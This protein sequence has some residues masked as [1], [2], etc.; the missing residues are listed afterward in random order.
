MRVKMTYNA[1]PTSSCGS[2]TYG[3]VE[4]YTVNISLTARMEDASNTAISFNLYPNP[5]NGEVLNISNL[6]VDSNYR[7]FNMIGQ[8]FG[9]GKI[10][11]QSINVGSLSSGTYLIEVSNANGTTS[12]RFIKQ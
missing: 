5:V 3:Q 10:E 11:N 2:F 6:E 12:K 8:E 7:I 9:K 1:T 4:D